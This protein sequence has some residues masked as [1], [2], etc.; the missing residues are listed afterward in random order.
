MRV[1]VVAGPTQRLRVVQG[2]GQLAAL[3]LHVAVGDPG[4]QAGEV[5]A[6]PGRSLR[7]SDVTD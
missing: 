3:D 4:D 2:R 6:Q 1:V 5:D 7:I